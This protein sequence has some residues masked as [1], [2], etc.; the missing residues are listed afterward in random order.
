LLQATLSAP[1]C[2]RPST[3]AARKPPAVDTQSDEAD[4]PGTGAA[5]ASGTDVSA[6]VKVMV[7]PGWAGSGGR[8]V[9]VSVTASATPGA[10]EAAMVR[11]A[12]RITIVSGP[13]DSVLDLDAGDP[14]VTFAW[15]TDHALE[16]FQ[17][18]GPARPNI[19]G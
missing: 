8:T 9:G 18:H 4:L 14:G 5:A 13:D 16:R 2:A 17:S 7:A 11:I 3:R 10:G 15:T 6:S 19:A 12:P 1:W